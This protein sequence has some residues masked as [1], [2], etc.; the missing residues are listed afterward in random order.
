AQPTRVTDFTVPFGAFGGIGAQGFT[1][2]RSDF[3]ADPG[4]VAALQAAGHFSF[5]PVLVTSAPIETFSCSA[6][7]TATCTNASTLDVK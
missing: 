3:T 4:I 6:A 1:L 5:S 2:S 7:A